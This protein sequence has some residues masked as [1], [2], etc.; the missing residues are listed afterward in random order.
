MV[1]HF[2]VFALVLLFLA[3]GSI[4]SVSSYGLK[5]EQAA[6]HEDAFRTIQ[7]QRPVPRGGAGPASPSGGRI[8]K[9]KVSKIWSTH[10]G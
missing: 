10:F 5:A 7:A 3:P 8:L 6:V 4:L 1:L 2:I 9:H